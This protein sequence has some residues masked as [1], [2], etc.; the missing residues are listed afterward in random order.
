MCGWMHLPRYIDKLRLHLAGQLPADYQPNLGK[1][2]DGL[3]L[4]HAG[5]THEQMLEVVK[6]TITDGQV[7]DWIRIHAPKTAAEKE[8]HRLAMLRRVNRLPDFI[9][10]RLRPEIEP[11][12]IQ[13]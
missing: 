3:W 10:I 1:G 12:G 9:P 5:L 4:T 13:E 6:P 11:A 7:C 8:A 2:F